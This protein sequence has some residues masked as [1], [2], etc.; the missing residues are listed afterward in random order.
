MNAITIRT[1][2]WK[3]AILVSAGIALCGLT[4]HA[5]TAGPKTDKL[6]TRQI[7]VVIDDFGNG[8]TGTDQMLELPIKLTVAVMPFLP[9]TKQDAEAAYRKGHD[10]IVHLPME[11]IRGKRS[12]LGPGSI[13][14]DLTEEEIRNRVEAAIAAVPHAIGMNNHMGSKAT[15]DKRVM[16]IVLQVCKER[17]LFFLDSRTSYRT[18]VPRIAKEVGVITLHNDV[19][20]DD[21]YTKRHVLKQIAEVK[22]FLSKNDQCIVI[23]HVGPSGLQT[24]GVLKKT[25]PE[26]QSNAKFVPLT[27]LL[28][29][30]EPFDQG[31]KLR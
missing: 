30:P 31:Q 8:M 12:W 28:P 18:V 4:V 25:I 15:A 21:V 26:L 20:L 27:Q 5:R 24:S 3:I 23:G 22:K 1:R 19:F 16:R 13:T 29:L 6:I 10:V 14:T 7:A 2:P 17:G 9:T 11:P